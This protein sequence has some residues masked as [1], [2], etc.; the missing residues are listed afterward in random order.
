MRVLLRKIHPGVGCTL[1][2][3]NRSRKLGIIDQ[4][5]ALPKRGQGQQ[6]PACKVVDNFVVVNSCQD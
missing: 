3:A 1:G 5:L 6:E 4:P 2:L